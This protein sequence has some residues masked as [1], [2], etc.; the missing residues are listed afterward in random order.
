MS[1][2]L[3]DELLQGVARLP[4]E[5]QQNVLAFVKGLTLLLEGTPAR[6]C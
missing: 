5:E 3:Q 4:E 6:N 2:K 1:Q